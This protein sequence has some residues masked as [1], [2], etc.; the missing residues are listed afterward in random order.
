MLMALLGAVARDHVYAKI[1]QFESH[2]GLNLD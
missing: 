1:T 2:T